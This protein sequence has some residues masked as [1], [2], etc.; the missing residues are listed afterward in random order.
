MGNAKEKP[1]RDSGKERGMSRNVKERDREE[2][3]ELGRKGQG[4]L[5]EEGR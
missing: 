5:G 1:V 4:T 2:K 3:G